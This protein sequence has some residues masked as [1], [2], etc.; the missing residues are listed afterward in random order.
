MPRILFVN[1]N[2]HGHINP[3][4]PLVKRLVNSGF[5]VDYYCS[6]QF[7]EKIRSTGATFIEYSAE[8]NTF[9]A[10]YRPTDRHPFYMLMEYILLYAEAVLPE[11]LELI[12]ENHYDMVIGDSLF[13]A[14]VFL[15]EM[16]QIPVVSSHASFAMSKA[17]VPPN[18]LVPG[19]HP[20]L[21]HCYEVLHRI[22]IAYALPVPD[23]SDVFMSQAEHNVVY[24]IPEFNGD[25]ALDFSKYLFAGSSVE[26]DKET[27][28]DIFAGKMNQPVVYI[29]LGSVNTGFLDF[30]KLCIE[31]FADS[32]YFVVMSIGHQCRIEQLGAIPSNFHIG[33]FLP[34]LA[35]LKNADVFVTHAGFNSVHESL[36]FG[37]PMLALPIVNDQ[38]MV[39]GRITELAIGDV[40]SFKDMD[41][42]T[43]RTK[44]SNLLSNSRY[45][46][47]CQKMSL[48]LRETDRLAVVLKAFEKLLTSE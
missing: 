5:H 11:V 2:L 19:I 12:R 7:H 31:A 20:Q 47:N 30:Y 1:A 16:L 46:D 40:G 28:D 4:I 9:L 37:V 21:D 23:L 34:Q 18:M 17:P 14:P 27:A 33:S 6:R 22:C 45:K 39:A 15:K 25:D 36:F 43:L 26:E 32:E 42:H 29:S 35:I 8:M 48:L 44:V 38:P 13:G 24:T 3:T 41:P 10:A